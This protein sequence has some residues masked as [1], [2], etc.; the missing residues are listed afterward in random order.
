M[1]VQARRGTRLGARWRARARQEVRRAAGSLIR[2]GAWSGEDASSSA[3][4]TDAGR[5]TWTCASACAFMYAEGR[6]ERTDGRTYVMTAAGA[7]AEGD[8]R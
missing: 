7:C 8:E 2:P 4:V 3:R 5:P 1:Y 6:V